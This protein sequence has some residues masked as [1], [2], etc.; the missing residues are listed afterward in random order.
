[1]FSVEY[2]LGVSQGG[3]VICPISSGLLKNNFCVADPIQEEDI[4]WL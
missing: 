4:S 3:N 2:K 1:M